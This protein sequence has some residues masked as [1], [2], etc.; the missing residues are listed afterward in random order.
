M[1]N[2]MIYLPED[3]I[4]EM[5][6]LLGSEI[7]DFKKSY[8][9]N[10][11]VGLR[12]NCLKASKEDFEK[13]IPFKLEPVGWAA[14]G[15]YY[16]LNDHPGRTPLHEAGAFY[17]QEPSAMSAVALLDPK[18]GDYVLDLCAAPGG[19][20]TQI[21]GRL[22]GQGLLVSN[23][24]VK[25]RAGILSQNI[26]RMGVTNAIVVN[27]TPYGLAEHFR[28]YFDKILVDA[29]CSGEGM[30]RKNDTAIGEWSLDNVSLCADRQDDILE[31]AA[32]MLK[33]GGKLMY[34]TCT[35]APGED[36]GTILRFIM[37]HPEFHVVPI[38]LTGG[39][40]NG[41]FAFVAEQDYAQN[42]SDSQREQIGNTVRLWPHK[43]VGEGHFM[44][45]L[46][47]GEDR[48]EDF[49]GFVRGGMMKSLHAREVAPFLEFQKQH[50]YTEYHP[51]RQCFF[52]FGDHLYML[53]GDAPTLK[54]IKVLRPG[55]MLGTYLKNRFEPA[56]ALAMS[57]T[58]SVNMIDFP[59]DS[60]ELLNYLRGDVYRPQ[61]ENSVNSV[62]AT[63]REP[64][65]PW[66]LILCDSISCGWAKLAGNMYKNHYPR[67]LRRIN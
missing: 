9:S 49:R 8:E 14:E 20:S 50:L 39:M 37:R 66:T 10:K 24:I 7:E 42:A 64:K 32:S 45:L 17:I 58:E 59:A 65:A 56:H 19:K 5:E 16:D 38:A 47:K 12:R 23:E 55:L 1:E 22:L 36:E 33:T 48:R 29:P 41:N 43:V 15:Y 51:D 53:P 54:G 6:E 34:S 31:C 63:I 67:G 21:A 27:E 11:Y 61:G 3:F 44:A 4:S 52:L 62:V 25:N 13:S 40:A 2:E 26:E 46:Q 35:F 28:D 30:F 60:P 18:P 57:L